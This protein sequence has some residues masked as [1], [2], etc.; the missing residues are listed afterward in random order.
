MNHIADVKPE[1]GQ[2]VWLRTWFDVYTH[3]ATYDAER[4]MWRPD[5][6]GKSYPINENELHGDHWEPYLEEEA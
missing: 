4:K 3:T 5:D 2:K 6:Y 1:H